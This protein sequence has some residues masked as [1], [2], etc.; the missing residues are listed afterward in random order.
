MAEALAR[1]Y[2]LTGKD[3][4]RAR[5]EETFRALA[6]ARVEMLVNAPGLLCAFEYLER[7][8]MI[9][10]AGE[11]PAANELLRAAFALTAPAKIVQRVTDGSKLP[12]SHPAHGKGP[13]GGKAAAYICVGK[14][15]GLPVTKAKDLGAAG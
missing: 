8:T 5:A 7:P 6:P 12:P 11:G 4:Y 9:V 3:A 15:C 13:V 1:L 14:T 2:H 10:V